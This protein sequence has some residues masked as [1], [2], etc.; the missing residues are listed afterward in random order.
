MGWRFCIGGGRGVSFL[1]R[2]KGRVDVRCEMGWKLGMFWCTWN[3]DA[4]DKHYTQVTRE[5]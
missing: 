2:S 1:G 5:A 4:D 3:L